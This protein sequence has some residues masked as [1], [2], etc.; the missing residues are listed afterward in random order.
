ML[1]GELAKMIRSMIGAPG[2][3]ALDARLAEKDD[4]WRATWTV[5]MCDKD[6]E[7]ARLREENN[8]LKAAMKAKAEDEKWT[9]G[10][11]G[12]ALPD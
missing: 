1:Q 12:W 8:R 4:R 2:R 11:P 5:Q 3:A 7:I 6:A 9:R 10:N